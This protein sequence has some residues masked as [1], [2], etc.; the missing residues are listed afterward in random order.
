[1]DMKLNDCNRIFFV[2]S[3]FISLVS[4]SNTDKS[5]TSGPEVIPNE[6]IAKRCI[7]GSS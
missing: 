4:L 5:L 3:N 6:R 1:M 2:E 7:K